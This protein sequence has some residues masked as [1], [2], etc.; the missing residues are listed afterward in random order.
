MLGV[1]GRA[2]AWARLAGNPAWAFMTAVLAYWTLNMLLEATGLFI[3]LTSFLLLV[4][5]TR[6][7]FPP[8]RVGGRHPAP[9]RRVPTMAVPM[10]TIP[11]GVR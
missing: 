2:Y 5:L 1:T 3:D 6:V 11:R 10:L 4:M 8:R 7:A 9:R